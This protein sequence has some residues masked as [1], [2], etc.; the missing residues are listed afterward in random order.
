MTYSKVLEHLG[1]VLSPG[2][3]WKCLEAVVV[4][5]TRRCFSSWWREHGHT[6]NDLGCNYVNAEAEKVCSGYSLKK[7]LWEGDTR[8]A[9]LKSSTFHQPLAW[10]HVE[11][12]SINKIL[13]EESTLFILRATRNPVQLEWQAQI[14]ARG[15]GYCCIVDNLKCQHEDFLLYLLDNREPFAG[16]TL[17]QAVFS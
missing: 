6:E 17:E 1:A 11:N 4:T 9:S 8:R 13:E 5:A 14:S 7:S 10:V 2:D 16:C 15:L 3:S 12:H